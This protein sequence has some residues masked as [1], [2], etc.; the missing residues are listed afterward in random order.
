MSWER[1]ST[2][3]LSTRHYGPVF[4]ICCCA[5][6]RR[7]PSLSTPLHS[8]IVS[9]RD[10]LSAE[11]WCVMPR[12]AKR[13]YLAIDAGPIF[14]DF[15][16]VVAVVESLRDITPQKLAEGELQALASSDGLTAIGN[17]RFFDQRLEGEW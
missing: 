11:N 3:G 7:K 4:L 9:T 1:G 15:G 2:G 10:G 12:A 17:R 14:N 13:L 8:D 16:E 6:R 5:A